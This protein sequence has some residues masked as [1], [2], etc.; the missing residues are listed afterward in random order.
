MVQKADEALLASIHG[1]RVAANICMFR[2]SA[3]Q[4]A[5]YYD[6]RIGHG[7]DWDLS[8]RLS[9]LGWDN[10]YCN[11]VLAAYRVWMDGGCCERDGSSVK[12]GA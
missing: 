1:Y 12:F 3:L 9:A 5:N 7:E 10:L 8:V 4:Q 6:E 11:E 2:T